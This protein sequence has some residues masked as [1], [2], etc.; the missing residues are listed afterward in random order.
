M[1]RLSVITVVV[2]ALLVFSS[3]PAV[4][5]EDF[6]VEPDKKMTKAFEDLADACYECAGIAEKK[7]LNLLARSYYN[8]ALQYEYDHKKTRKR[9]GFKKKKKKWVLVEDMLPLKDSVP[10]AKRA[11]REQ[12]LINETASIRRKAADRIFELAT[13]EKLDTRTRML[14]VFHTIRMLPDHRGAQKAIRS[15]LEGQFAVH[16]LDDLYWSARDKWIESEADGKPI[17]EQTDYEKKS[18]MEMVKTESDW[19]VWHGRIGPESKAW[20]NDFAK[21]GEAS[22]NQVFEAL[23]LEEP[24]PPTKRER[25]LHLSVF[26]EREDFKVFVNTC[27]SHPDAAYRREVAEAGGGMNVYHPFGAVWLYPGQDSSRWMHDGISHEL[28]SMEVQ[29]HTSD[30]GFWIMK[31]FGYLMSAR[32]A[33]ST[34]ARFFQTKKSQVIESGGVDALPGFGDSPC[35]WRLLVAM[36]VS[37]GKEVRA[38]ELAKAKEFTNHT[39]AH[40]FA[41]VEFMLLEKKEKFKA[42]LLDAL[43]ERNRRRADKLPPEN[44][45]EVLNRLV[46]AMEIDRNALHEEFCAWVLKTYVRL[47]AEED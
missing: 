7:G 47:P 29:R 4:A 8:H 11:E 40:A 13:N 39:M 19:V 16:A 36:S 45:V 9:M 31:G 28:A 38:V 42:F 22:R 14:A 25:K 41:F 44:N 17:E 26:D 12:A 20:L 23:G 34:K 46:T 21:F 37:A 33:S 27:S 3:K 2:L 1:K 35:G 18:K 43:K 15:R 32:M 30:A 6:G 10:Q 5:L 24:K